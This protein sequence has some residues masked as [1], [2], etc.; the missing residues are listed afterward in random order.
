MTL[1]LF[2]TE[3]SSF[4]K[5]LH[6]L[7]LRAADDRRTIGKSYTKG[8]MA[9]CVSDNPEIGIDLEE[10]KARAPE[11]IEHF[12]KKFSTFQIIDAQKTTDIQWFYR[13]WTAMESYFK[14][15][16]TGFGTPKDFTIDMQRQSVL[17][18]G[19]EV[20]WFEYFDM[21]AFLICLCS[22]T[23]FLKQDVQLNYH[24]W[25]DCDEKIRSGVF[26]SRL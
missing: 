9:V 11:T 26:G 25:E 21:G 20:A 2:N 6:M 17:R 18:D 4:V 15:S 22:S 1:H 10:K 13:A 12:I 16:G 19:E 5:D 7:S 24:G 8:A 14:L 23:R 3:S